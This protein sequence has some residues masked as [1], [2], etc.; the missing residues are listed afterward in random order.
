LLC[1]GCCQCCRTIFQ[2]DSF[3]GGSLGIRT[4]ET[5]RFAGFQDRCNRPLCQTSYPTILTSVFGCSLPTCADYEMSSVHA[6]PIASRHTRTLLT[7]DVMSANWLAMKM[8]RFSNVGVP[9]SVT[10]SKKWWSSCSFTP[11]KR[12]RRKPRSSTMPLAGSRGP[13]TLTSAWYVCPWMR[14]LPAVSISR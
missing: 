1:C 12:W 8:Q 9:R 6:S 11:S 4:L 5:F 2:P 3:I 10:S 7:W 14:R 13:V